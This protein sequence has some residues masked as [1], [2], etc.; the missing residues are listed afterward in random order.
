[1][2]YLYIYLGI[3]DSWVRTI[4]NKL[5]QSP[6]GTFLANDNRGK[7]KNRPHR[8]PDEVSKHVYD[9]INSFPRVEAHYCRS[10]TTK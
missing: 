2:I 6:N 4:N 8:V 7:H 1:M 10:N 5:Q 3:S 9:H